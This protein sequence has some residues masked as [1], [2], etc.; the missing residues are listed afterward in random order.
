M[1]CRYFWH[2]MELI[3]IRDHFVMVNLPVL[4][5]NQ[6]Y[7]PLNVCQVRRAVVLVYQGKAEML[8]MSPR[9]GER[10]FEVDFSPVRDG[11][12]KLEVIAT[13][14]AGQRLG[15]DSQPLIVAPLSKE[16]DRL[17]RD[18][19]LLEILADKTRGRKVDISA[20]PDLID[21]IVQR[22]TGR[23]QLNQ[24]EPAT[25]T[26][27]FNFPILFLAFV[28]LLTTEWLLR[29]RWHLR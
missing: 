29:K 5:L 27:L 17:G 7:E 11:K 2:R 3:S 22:M 23:G 15:A 8:P 14:S 10:L 16:T 4:V 18:D 19:A 26:P 6:S 24:P 28:G 12:Y 9:P 1:S 25:I 21:Q 20:L 13:D